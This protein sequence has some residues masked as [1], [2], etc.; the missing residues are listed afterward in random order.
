M[1]QEIDNL[2]SSGDF[3]QANVLLEKMYNNL[4]NTQKVEA[5]KRFSVTA[6]DLPRIYK[7]S[8]RLDEAILISTAYGKW[9]EV[10]YFESEKLNCLAHK[11]SMM[12]YRQVNL[13]LSSQVFPWLGFALESNKN[14]YEYLEEQ[15]TKIDTRAKELAERITK[16]LDR[17]NW[18][19]QVIARVHLQLADYY[20]TLYLHYLQKFM[21]G[22]KV[23]SK[24]AN[25]SL[26]R[27][28]NLFLYLYSKYERQMILEARELSFKYAQLAVDVFVKDSDKSATAHALYNYAI[29][30]YTC[31]KFTRALKVLRDAEEAL[32][33]ERDFFLLNQIVEY[34]KLIKGQSHDKRDY[35]EELGLARPANY[36]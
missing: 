19:A 22:G 34:R 5:V 23:K 11:L 8:H 13:K 25:S 17:K 24:F 33:K 12:Y 28:W 16:D 3:D 10:I 31:N 20:S 7:L 35:V 26:V 29:K 6:K 27:R 1:F 30:L 21:R 18:S 4:N 9:D 14:E 2:I 32:D 15:V 36:G